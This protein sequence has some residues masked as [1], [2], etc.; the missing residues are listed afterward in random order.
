MSGHRH[1]GD[2]PLDLLCVCAP[3][4]ERLLQAELKELGAGPTTPGRGTV[5]LTTTPAV[6][7]QIAR[8][9][10][11]AEAVRLQ[12][13]TF[14]ARDVRALDRGL[15]A[16]PLDAWLPAR[17]TV[18]IDVA[19]TR[20]RLYHSGLVTERLAEAVRAHGRVPEIGGAARDAVAML[21]LRLFRDEAVLRVELAAARAHRRGWRE[22]VG[23]ASLRET[24]AAAVLRASGWQPREGG[25]LLDPCCGAGTILLEARAI[26]AGI[27]PRDPRALAVARCDAG[28][29][30]GGGQ[31]EVA[32]IGASR[33]AYLGS[34]R[35]PD[36]VAAARHND[37][38]QRGVLSLPPLE[39]AVR[40]LADAI[41]D[42]PAGADLVCN[43]PWGK[44]TDDDA[45]AT[46]RRV[47]GALRG[48]RDLGLVTVLDGSGRAHE[49]GLRGRPLLRYEQGGAKV[50]LLEL[51]RRKG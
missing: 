25:A 31:A 20:S 3:G 33:G 30:W 22:H 29:R 45:Y 50:T 37:A 24:V 5:Q 10:R 1:D 41:A 18:R 4:L 34:D 48:R 21:H 17:S 38:S 15:A 28:R 49:A 23:V 46:L 36:A 27:P 19:C 44:R 7:L 6:A 13:A 40:D 14:A 8:W 42:A 26:D 35:D 16:A 9:S 43:L 51:R 39:L 47:A 2:A 32:A 11:I 12:I